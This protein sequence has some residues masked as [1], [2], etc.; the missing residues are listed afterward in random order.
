MSPEMHKSIFTEDGAKLLWFAKALVAALE[1]SQTK[2]YFTQNDA[3]KELMRKKPKEAYRLYWVELLGRAHFAAAASLVRSYRWT[4]GM[5]AAEQA[6][7]FLPY[8]ANLR[9]LI[10]SAA[11]SFDS[12]KVI[13][14][15][16]SSNVFVVESSLSKQLEA[17]AIC[18]EM[19]DVL[20]HFSHGRKLER[21]ELAPESHK[22]KAP[23]EYIRPLEAMGIPGAYELYSSLC[24]FTHPASWS[25]S[26]L[27]EQKSDDLFVMTPNA[28]RRLIDQLCVECRETM[29]KLLMAAFNPS[30]LVL[31]VLLELKLPEFHVPLVKTFDLSNIKAWRD[32][33]ALLQNRVRP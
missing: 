22:A 32:C 10:E 15:T 9:A 30:I 33:E 2:Y 28:D 11:D 18:R 16:I 14:Q 5:V 1:K 31:R 19:E 29:P 21:G 17:F 4:Q 7:L 23:H 8:C 24:Q 3:F 27:M 20:I 12:L 13:A 6:G 25:V 26:Y